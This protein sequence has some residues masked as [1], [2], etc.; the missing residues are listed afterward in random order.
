MFNDVDCGS[1]NKQIREIRGCEHDRQP[2][3][4]AG[5]TITRCPL[6]YVGE[7]EKTYLQAYCEY[8]KGYLPNDGGWL[9]QTVKFSQ[10]MRM[11]EKLVNKNIEE[12]NGRSTFKYTPK[13]C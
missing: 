4:I 11:V 7:I 12:K 9:D 8:E 13:A 5:V 10:V 3:E 6:F 1:C 2:I